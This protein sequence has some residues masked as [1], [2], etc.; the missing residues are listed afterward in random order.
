MIS[1]YNV[2]LER[3]NYLLEE[4]SQQYLRFIYKA[5]KE[6]N[7]TVSIISD[8]A[9]QEIDEINNAKS[10][11]VAPTSKS[12]FIRPK[13]E[14]DIEE[15]DL[16]KITY[17]KG[18]INSDTKKFE[19]KQ[20]FAFCYFKKGD[21]EKAKELL[22]KINSINPP[23]EY[24]KIEPIE[25][26]DLIRLIKHEEL[27]P[28]YKKIL[29]T[30]LGDD[31]NKVT[32]ESITYATKQKEYKKDKGIKEFPKEKED[33]EN[34]KAVKKSEELYGVLDPEVINTANIFFYSL[35]NSKILQ[36]IIDFHK[37]S[38]LETISSIEKKKAI[39][40]RNSKINTLINSINSITIKD[41][42]DLSAPNQKSKTENIKKVR[43]AIVTHVIYVKIKS[44]YPEDDILFDKIYT[45]YKKSEGRQIVKIQPPSDVEEKPKKKEKK[46]KKEEPA[47]N[48]DKDASEYILTYYNTKSGD[49]ET[50]VV[51]LTD[52]QAKNAKEIAE[53]NEPGYKKLKKAY[54]DWDMSTDPNKYSK[55]N[56]PN[57]DILKGAQTLL[58]GITK[59]PLVSEMSS[60]GGGA[61]P[62]TGAGVTP[63]EGEG[64]ATKYAFGGAG[65]T[66]AKRKKGIVDTKKIKNV[67]SENYFDLKNDAKMI[68]LETVRGYL[69]NK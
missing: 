52:I 10:T 49:E 37:R 29:I 2:I 38:K 28:K 8:F 58:I 46:P 60:T 16:Y 66:K 57:I 14:T 4:N 36:N 32:N 69:N 63:G 48:I 6:K 45:V 13:K 24:I 55:E 43:D 42:N 51:S 39:D 9:E 19:E 47:K 44:E 25:F 33:S 65:G 54:T 1:F 34:I 27:G 59:K 23:K 21:F 35:K 11:N 15:R 12:H 5:P 31:F 20:L 7:I 3:L 40:N 56:M 17:L 50:G 68:F 61:A 41:L 30:L 64:V 18:S 53:E 26:K 62:G 22:K 67:K